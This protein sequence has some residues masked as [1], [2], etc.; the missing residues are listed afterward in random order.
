MLTIKQNLPLMAPLPIK[1]KI[2][3]INREMG[4][5]P[6]DLDP[7]RMPMKAKTALL[8]CDT[9]RKVLKRRRN[10]VKQHQ[11]RTKRS[12]SSS[13]DKRVSQENKKLPT[14]QAHLQMLNQLMVTRSNNKRSQDNEKILK[15]NATG[16]KDKLMTPMLQPRLRTQMQMA[17]MR[18]EP[19]PTTRKRPPPTNPKILFTKILWNS[20][21]P[22]SS[23]PS[24]KNTASVTGV[25]AAA[26]P[27]SPSKQVFLQCPTNY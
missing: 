14:D 27:S 17:K 25:K 5:V 11:K 26:R 23:S 4:A 12:P 13:T 6:E 20:K 16:Q 18:K 1:N 2:K 22:K 8:N 15:N 3:E 7:K 10:R 9:S 24:G 19:N 21:R